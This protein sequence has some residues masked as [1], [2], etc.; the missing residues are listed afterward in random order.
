M[1]RMNV[2]FG[3]CFISREEITATEAN[4][5]P[6]MSGSIFV[7]SFLP[8]EVWMRKE[9]NKKEKGRVQIRR[10]QDEEYE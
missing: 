4:R 10:I 1:N 8:F 3:L 7:R 9:Q 2:Y 5:K 6:K